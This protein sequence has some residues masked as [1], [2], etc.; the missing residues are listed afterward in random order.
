MNATANP[1]PGFK[2]HPDY[3]VELRPSTA[4]IRVELNGVTI[5]DSSSVLEVTESSHRP[6]LYFPRKDV[7]S[8]LLSPS[9]TR[10]FCPFKGQASYW[11][12]SVESREV[13]DIAWS[14]EAPYD[15]VGA[16]AGYIA[17]YGDRVDRVIVDDVALER[18]G[19][20]WTGPRPEG[21]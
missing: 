17:F 4:H 10:T 21:L 2:K 8:D 13:A 7:R 5:A 1:A 9:E 3:R 19:P 15:E 20:G 12:A 16:L 14:Y 6:V 18:V 11:S